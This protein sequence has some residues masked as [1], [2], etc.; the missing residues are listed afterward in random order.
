[1]GDLVMKKS[2]GRKGFTLPEVLV[3]LAIVATLA[4][5][6][7]PALNSQL[8]KGDAGRAASDLV[9]LQTAIGVFASDVRRYPGDMAQ[10]NDTAAFTTDI[11][12]ASLAN[13][14]TKWKGPYLTKTLVS[15]N[16]PTAFGATILGDFDPLTSYLVIELTNMTQ[17]DFNKVDQI[18][19][20]TVS[21]T[22][23]QFRWVTGDTARYYAT[24]LQ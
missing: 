4:A 9:S 15:G 13:L 10:L 2:R 18:I 14:K 8:S 1:M 16:L 3:T 7:L 11:N 6:L 22:S 17:T 20:E 24:P 19:D 21:T 23:G 5:V 12:G